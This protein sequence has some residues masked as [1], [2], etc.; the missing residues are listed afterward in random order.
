MENLPLFTEI[1]GDQLN[2]VLGNTTLLN[3]GYF[4]TMRFRPTSKRNKELYLNSTL[5]DDNIR[6]F[7]H[8]ASG[9]CIGKRYKNPKK[10]ERKK[11]LKHFMVIHENNSDVLKTHCHGIVF[12]PEKLN[13]D[14]F[15]DKIISSWLK[16]DFGTI[17]NG[18]KMFDFQKIYSRGVINYIFTEDQKYYDSYGASISI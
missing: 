2:T 5:V 11:K 10:S 14:E 7:L 12:K 13:D 4:I 3:T 9:Y 18:D 16:T 17:G 8:F 6:W 1:Y 15:R